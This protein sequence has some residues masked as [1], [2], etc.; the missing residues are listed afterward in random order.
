MRYPGGPGGW[1]PV[2][3]V[4]HDE[5]FVFRFGDAYG[6]I[7][8]GRGNLARFGCVVR[9][10]NSP[11]YSPATVGV[12]IGKAGDTIRTLRNSSGARIQNTRDAVA[13]PHSENSQ[14]IKWLYSLEECLVP[15]PLK[16]SCA[17][18]RYACLGVVLLISMLA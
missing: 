5:S 13:N 6:V 9:D 10:S 16:S 2:L 7:I 18:D 14:V 17:L 4:N 12:L 15:F 8:F 3:A 11:E 1:V